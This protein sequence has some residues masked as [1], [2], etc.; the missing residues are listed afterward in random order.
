MAD[1]CKGLKISHPEDQSISTG[2]R[3]CAHGGLLQWYS[4]VLSTIHNS[5]ISF[6]SQA[7][8]HDNLN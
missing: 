1:V 6:L 7:N 5:P 4:S 2:S 3:I 8:N